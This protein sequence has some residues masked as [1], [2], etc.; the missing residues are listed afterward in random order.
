M[1]LTGTPWISASIP[2]NTVD[3]EDPPLD[4]YSDYFL[5][6]EAP[7]V[8]PGWD[9]SGQEGPLDQLSVSDI[10]TPVTF[11]VEGHATVAELADFLVRGKIHRALVQEDGRLEGIVTAMDVLRAVAEG[12][13]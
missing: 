10:L 11:S 13:I 12:K 1:P 2:E 9:T 8:G 3:P 5:P 4:P 6:E 7:V